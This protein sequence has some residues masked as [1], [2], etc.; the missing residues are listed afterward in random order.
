MAERMRSPLGRAYGLGSARSGSAQ[1]LRNR[2]LAVA[3]V[4]LGL[5]WVAAII[6]HAGA[7][8]D[9]FTLWVREPAT[10]VLLVL[11]VVATF[12]HIALGLQEVIED[13][14]HGELTK[15]GVLTAVRFGCTLLAAAGLFAVLRIALGIS[16]D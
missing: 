1:W 3:L 16:N 8:F 5:W 6:C 13:Y 14:V 7:D 9:H 4:P 12:W 10:A 11:T 15:L 2:L